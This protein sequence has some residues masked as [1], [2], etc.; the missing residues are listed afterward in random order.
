MRTFKRALKGHSKGDGSSAQGLLTIFFFMYQIL[1]HL[2]TKISVKKLKTTFK[3]VIIKCFLKGIKGSSVINTHTIGLLE[4]GWDI[5]VLTDVGGQVHP[6]GV[7]VVLDPGVAH[8]IEVHPGH[9]VW[10]GVLAVVELSI[11]VMQ[12]HRLLTIHTV[13]GTSS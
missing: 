5:K 10:L 3:T 4:A 11:L 7:Q 6:H 9:T 8:P 13:L 12:L 1:P 2:P